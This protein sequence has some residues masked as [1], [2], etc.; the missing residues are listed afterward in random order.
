MRYA[1]LSSGSCANSYIFEKNGLTFVIDNGLSCKSFEERCTDFGFHPG[2]INFIFLTHLHSDHLK[3][4]ELLSRK[5]QIPVVAHKNH[6]NFDLGS[7]GV[8]KKLDVEEGREYEFLHLKFQPFAASHDSPH[9]LGFHFSFDGFPFTLITDT[10]KVTE[11]MFHFARRSELLF[12]EANY[13]PIMLAEGPYP[14]YLKKRISSHEGHLS[15]EEAGKFMT[16]I[17]SS[18]ESELKHIYLCH[19]SKNNNTVEKVKEEV[20]QVYKG[21]VPWSV[22]PR[23]EA[24]MGIDINHTK[25]A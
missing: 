8:Y 17:T 19:L 11:E 3:G 22:C 20:S 24:V 16:E 15:N 21:D 14:P 10:G 4:V 13:S 2:K 6:D 12:L 5:Y 23:G 1:I 7:K 9:A 25:G 18:G